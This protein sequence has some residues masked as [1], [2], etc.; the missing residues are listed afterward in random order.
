MA[1]LEAVLS[2]GFDAVVADLAARAAAAAA[3]AD[4]EQRW[5][6]PEVTGRLDTLR[7][8]LRRADG[9]AQLAS[10]PACDREPPWP[11]SQPASVCSQT[12]DSLRPSISFFRSASTWLALEWMQINVC[13]S[14]HLA[15][16]KTPVVEESGTVVTLPAHVQWLR[17]RGLT[18]ACSDPR[19]AAG[20]Q[21][22]GAVSRG[23]AEMP[24]AARLRRGGDQHA[25]ARRHF[26]SDAV[27]VAGVPPKSGSRHLSHTPGASAACH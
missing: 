10:L 5:A 15:L 4:A 12:H 20:V 17:V 22:L 2:R 23:G 6:K 25:R 9:W 8:L 21:G 1:Q 16:H 7:M 24:A 27:G 18:L 14:A 3:A 19:R 13:Q 26:G 11:S